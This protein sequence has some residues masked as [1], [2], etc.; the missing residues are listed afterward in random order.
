VCKFLKQNF[1]VVK[2]F[3]FSKMKRKTCFKEKK[4]IVKERKK[5]K[6]KR[7]VIEKSKNNLFN[8]SIYLTKFLRKKN[9]ENLFLRASKNLHI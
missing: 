9:R 2:R 8:G 1:E 4:R 3:F 5:M 7:I 6:K